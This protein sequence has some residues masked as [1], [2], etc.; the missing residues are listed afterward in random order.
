MEYVRRNRRVPLEAVRRVREGLM[1]LITDGQMVSLRI[2]PPADE[3][4]DHTRGC[5]GGLQNISYYT[6]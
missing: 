6:Q 4:E 2:K 1:N 5:Q 3:G